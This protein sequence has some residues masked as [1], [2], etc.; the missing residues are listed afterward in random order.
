ML[1]GWEERK[2]RTRQNGTIYKTIVDRM[3]TNITLN[4]PLAT[5]TIIRK[6]PKLFITFFLRVSKKFQN[7]SPTNEQSFIGHAPFHNTAEKSS[8]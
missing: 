8:V 3:F 2:R 1:R 6:D 5:H 7:Y 4:I